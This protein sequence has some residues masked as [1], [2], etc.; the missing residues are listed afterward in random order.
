MDV[1]QSKVEIFGRRNGGQGASWPDLRQVEGKSL[2]ARLW[3]AL[4]LHACK[5]IRK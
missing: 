3:L 4:P 2:A 1:D 5:I